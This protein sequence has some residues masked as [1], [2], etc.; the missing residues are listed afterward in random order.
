MARMPKAHITDA[1]ENV[2]S[3]VDF[4]GGLNMALQ[5][6]LIADNE[7]QDCFNVLFDEEVGYVVPCKGSVKVVEFGNVKSLYTYRKSS[8]KQYLIAVDDSGKVYANDSLD[9]SSWNLLFQGSPVTYNFETFEDVLWITNGCDKIR[10]WNG[11]DLMV[12]D[13]KNR[14]FDCYERFTPA[15][16][17]AKFIKEWQNCLWLANTSR[18]GSELLFSRFYDE[19]GSYVKAYWGKSSVNPDLVGAWIS[20]NQILVAPEDGTEITGLAVYLGNLIVFKERAMYIIRGT[21]PQN[22]TIQRVPG[23]ISMIFPNTITIHQNLLTFLAKD[24]I[25]VFNG[26][27]VEKVSHKVDPLVKQITSAYVPSSYYEISKQEEWENGTVDTSYPNIATRGASS[28]KLTLIEPIKDDTDA[29]FLQAEQLV[30]MYVE[31]GKLH[32]ADQF[33]I[34]AQL[35]QYFNP[36]PIDNTTD[37][38]GSTYEEAQ[39]TV[40]GNAEMELLDLR[41]TLLF[42]MF[43]AKKIVLQHTL[44]STVDAYFKR[45]VV[46]CKASETEDIWVEVY[47]VEDFDDGSNEARRRGDVIMFESPTQIFGI[48]VKYWCVANSDG[49]T[50]RRRLYEWWFYRRNSATYI[51][52]EHDTGSIYVYNLSYFYAVGMLDIGSDVNKFYVSFYDTPGTPFN[53]GYIFEI[54]P[55]EIPSIPPYARLRYFKWKVSFTPRDCRPYNIDYLK[56]EFPLGGVWF[57]NPIYLGRVH[58]WLH[59]FANYTAEEQ[60]YVTFCIRSALSLEELSQAHWHTIGHGETPENEAIGDTVWC[61]LKVDLFSINPNQTSP[62]V[63]SLKLVF[64]TTTFPFEE[65]TAVSFEERYILV[66]PFFSKRNDIA[67]VWDKNK[68]WTKFSWMYYSAFTKWDDALLGGSGTY[69]GIYK[70]F[71]G[72]KFFGSIDVRPFIRLKYLYFHLPANYKLLR[73]IHLVFGEPPLDPPY[74]VRLFIGFGVTGDSYHEEK[75]FMVQTG[76]RLNYHIFFSFAGRKAKFFN[77]AIQGDPVATNFKLKEINFF[78]HVLPLRTV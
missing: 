44:F 3:L 65:P 64:H 63:E 49:K 77:I 15:L 9:S 29:D 66:V 50:F 40:S 31:G 14:V 35:R 60:H 5:P 61:Q 19:D 78:Y 47:K 34:E 20:I 51:S 56:Q 22:Y 8:G 75:L 39:Q 70:M 2:Y 16:P 67:I 25:Y 46:E 53:Q 58:K 68:N 12:M 30:N 17:L 72:Y 74:S 55:N 23:E 6:E 69:G 11:K 1:T 13:G 26:N 73:R 45:I 18:N 24:G 57:S 41:H 42:D 59:F 4:S 10:V 7:V 27:R 33:D 21:M 48:R 37:L 36:T 71:E 62:I 52:R 76:T 54:T 38:D 43:Y 32:V 28:G